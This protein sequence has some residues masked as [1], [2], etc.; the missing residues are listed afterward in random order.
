MTEETKK[1]EATAQTAEAKTAPAPEAPVEL[2]V[3]DLGN[4]KQIIDVASQRGA[5][6]PNEMTI[7]GTTYTKLESFLNAVAA[8]QKAAQPTAEGEKK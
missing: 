1:A 7:V 5:F 3:Q 2:T 8:Q 6:K 4:I